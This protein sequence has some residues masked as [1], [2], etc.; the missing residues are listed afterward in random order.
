MINR[1]G[2]T[3]IEWYDVD[4]LL[5]G[6]I[7]PPATD[8]TKPWLWD[9][10]GR[11]P[12]GQQQQ[13]YLDIGASGLYIR[14]LW[15]TQFY[16]QENYGSGVTSGLHG[17]FCSQVSGLYP[18]SSYNLAT[19]G[20]VDYIVSISGGSGGSTSLSGLTDVSGVWSSGTIVSWNGTYFVPAT[21][22]GLSIANSGNWEISGTSAALDAGLPA[23]FLASGVYTVKTEADV[24]Y[25]LSGQVDRTLLD[26]IYQQSGLYKVTIENDVRYAL[27]G[28]VLPLEG[29]I[30]TNI[31]SGTQ[32]VFNNRVSGVL[33]QFGTLT[34]RSVDTDTRYTLS[35][36]FPQATL[37]VRYALSG[38][39][40]AT[41]F[42][43]L[44]DVTGTWTSGKI[45]GYNGTYFL[46][47]TD[48]TGASLAADSD[49]VTLFVQSFS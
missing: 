45:V 35:G 32:G 9:V 13:P 1:R 30:L 37:D 19:K 26:P 36:L 16:V 28:R 18:V 14:K 20:Y 2:N 3:R 21:V 42:S 15:A 48:Q 47:T 23:R 10:W 8:T 24:R 46:P 34:V 41:S 43:G 4:L 49:Q 6:S 39:S 44:T 7:V 25:A 33:G 12:R 31:L 29:G 5:W 40:G 27:S 38:S 22:S 17:G 11:G